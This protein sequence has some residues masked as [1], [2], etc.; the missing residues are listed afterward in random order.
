MTKWMCRLLL[1]IATLLPMRAAAQR[2]A[3]DAAIRRTIAEQASAWAAGDGARYGGRLSVD[4]S[5]TNRFVRRD[6]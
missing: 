4:A 2:S 1:P 5:S 3:D 6:G